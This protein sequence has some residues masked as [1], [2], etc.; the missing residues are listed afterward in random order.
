MSVTRIQL[1]RIRDTVHKNSINL[2]TDGIAFYRF[3]TN[4]FN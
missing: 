1:D 2:K 4:A 3:D